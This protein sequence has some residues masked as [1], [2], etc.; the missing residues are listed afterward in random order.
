MSS[1]SSSLSRQ[2]EHIRDTRMSPDTIGFVF[3]GSFAPDAIATYAVGYACHY[4]ASRLRPILVQE[5]KPH[6]GWLGFK[7][8]A[9]QCA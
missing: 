7:R 4:V 9:E 5:L 1:S 6:S 8:T 2:F 3:L